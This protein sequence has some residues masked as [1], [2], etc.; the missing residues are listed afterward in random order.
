MNRLKN[1]VKISIILMIIIISML[2]QSFAFDI[3]AKELKSLGECEKLLTYNGTPI[4]TTYIVYESDGKNCPAYCL[5]VT[6][7]GAEHGSYIVNGGEKL[8]DVKVWRAIINGFPYKSIQELGAANEQ[9]AFTATKQAVYTMLYDRDVSSYGPVNSDAGR[10]TYQIYVNIVNAARSSSENIENNLQI[11]I[12]RVEEE[13][14]VDGV[15]RECVSKIYTVNSNVNA[16]EFEIY[17]RGLVPNGTIVTDENNNIKNKFRVGEKFKILIPIKNLNQCESFTIE[18]KANLETKPVVYGRTTVP[19]T[20]DYALTG[21][22]YEEISNNIIEDYFKNITK[23]VVV[24]KE[25]GTEER[26]TGV[27]F[28]LLDNNK[29]IVME[30]LETDE[31]GEIILE[32]MIPGKY[33]LKETKTLEN[34]NLYTDLIEIDL[35]LNEEFQITVNNTVRTVTEID[36]DFELVEVIPAYEETVYNVNKEVTVINETV[37]KLPVTGY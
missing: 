24:K 11:N 33:Y 7:P 3:G 23:I 8:Q 34:Y 25:Y 12:E 26:L 15:N 32:N 18:A 21:Y 28:N 37:K 14:K 20:Q 13:W 16:G 36:K 29:N 27:K 1:K 2:G 19:G 31:N 9:E 22:M 30:N 6:L 35:D 4:R 10:R 17:T 5:D